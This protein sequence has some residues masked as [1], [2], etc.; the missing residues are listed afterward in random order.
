[1]MRTHP[2]ASVI[3]LKISAR[4][5]DAKYNLS[6]I[7]KSGVP[8]PKAGVKCILN[9][10]AN[11]YVAIRIERAADKERG[12]FLY[13]SSIATGEPAGQ[14]LVRVYRG[15]ENRNQFAATKLVGKRAQLCE[16]AQPTR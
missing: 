9:Q 2:I 15:R 7:L 11:A 5:V 10:L 1:M 16:I 4:F 12:N 14:R 8:S 3:D 6:L 13:V